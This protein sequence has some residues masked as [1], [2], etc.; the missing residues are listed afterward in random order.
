MKLTA[1][2]MAPLVINHRLRIGKQIVLHESGYNVREP[3]IKAPSQN[4]EMV[5]NR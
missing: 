5:S 1:N 4:Q 3:I 2:L